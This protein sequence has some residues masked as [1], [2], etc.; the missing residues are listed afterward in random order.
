MT[1]PTSILAKTVK[2]YLELGWWMCWLAILLVPV[3]YVAIVIGVERPEREGS[4][5]DVLARFRID[6]S[7]LVEGGPSEPPIATLRDGQGKL[8][9]RSGSKLVAT[10][11]LGMMELVLALAVYVF[12]QLR[13]LFRC[14][15]RGEPFLE[16]NPRRVSRVGMVIA[17][18][19]LLMPFLKYFLSIPI[20][21]EI[22]IRGLLLA[23]PIEFSPELLFSG[24]AILVLAEIYGRACAL[25]REQSLTI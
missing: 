3:V 23:P 16:L 24:L 19:A 15:V 5:F 12:G 18:W 7:V 10:L 6:D 2:L 4:G 1:Q 11:S 20:L 9:V 8:R 21:R 13:A 14:V 17:A 25:H 22:E